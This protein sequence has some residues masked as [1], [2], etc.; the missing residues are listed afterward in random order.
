MF[1]GNRA[2][3]GEGKANNPYPTTRDS[4]TATPRKRAVR[5]L[6]AWLP[7][8]LLTVVVLVAEVDVPDEE[9]TD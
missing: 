7:A 1:L 3:S 4:A 2:V 9:D 5:R 8:L 6:V